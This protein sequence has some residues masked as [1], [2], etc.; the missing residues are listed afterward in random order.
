MIFC[1]IYACCGICFFFPFTC[2]ISVY[3]IRTPK[4]SGASLEFSHFF[5]K[6]IPRFRGGFGVIFN[7]VFLLFCFVFSKSSFY[8]SG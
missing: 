2:L 8:A 6:K 5:P 4:F 3:K 1:R 7:Y